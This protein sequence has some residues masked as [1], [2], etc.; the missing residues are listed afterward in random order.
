MGAPADTTA[1]GA[2]RLQ[3]LARRSTVV[4]EEAQERC[5][6]CGAPIAAEHRHLLDLESRELLC[7]CRACAILFDREGAGGGHFRLI[8]DRRVRVTDFALD[9]VAW[10]QLRL[11][12]DI[13]F[14]FHHSAAE[15]VSAFYPSPMGATESLLTLEAWTELEAANPVLRTLQPD[16]EALLVDRARHGRPGFGH[17]IVPI[18]ECYRLVGLIRTTWKGLTGGKVVWQEIGRF[19]DDLDRRS[20]TVTREAT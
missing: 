7:A 5:E 8:A 9:D 12:V 4:R 3:A 17:W 20:R 13:A 19:F 14:F 16:V 11:P 6:T 15:R 1:T 10:A 18:D 2:S